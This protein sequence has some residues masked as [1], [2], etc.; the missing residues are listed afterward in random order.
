MKGPVAI[1][2][3]PPKVEA[4][5]FTGGNAQAFVDWLQGGRWDD[6]GIWLRQ[7]FPTDE[8]IQDN[9]AKPDEPIWALV[10]PAGKDRLDIVLGK[11]G[12]LVRDNYGTLTGMDERDFLE[13]WQIAP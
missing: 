9:I 13:Q 8:D 5:Q 10:I 12:W 7:R 2:R 4:M 6:K 3:R 1:V 11:G